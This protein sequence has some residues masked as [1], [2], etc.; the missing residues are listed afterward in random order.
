MQYKLDYSLALPQSF[1]PISAK[2]INTVSG[3]SSQAVSLGSASNLDYALFT[4][5]KRPAASSLFGDME[6]EAATNKKV[7][8]ES[9][10]TDSSEKKDDNDDNSE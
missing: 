2:P 5:S 1:A 8:S 6:D 4:P 10:K 9:N 3:T 7:S